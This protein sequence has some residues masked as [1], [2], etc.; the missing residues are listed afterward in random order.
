MSGLTLYD[1]EFQLHKKGDLIAHFEAARQTTSGDPLYSAWLARDGS[2]II[3]ERNIAAGTLL[4]FFNKGSIAFATS[5][6][7][8]GALT[9][10]EYNSLFS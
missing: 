2:Y 8:R 6:S 3:M 10:V 1:P 9:Y 5:W 7:G 4:Y